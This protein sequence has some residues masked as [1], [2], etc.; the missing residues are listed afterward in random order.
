VSRELHT[1][2][3]LLRCPN[4]GDGKRVHEAVV[5]TLDHLRAWPAS[6]PW[7][8]FEPSVSASETYCRESA[9]AFL[10][11]SALVYLAFDDTGALVASTSLHGIDW[12]VPKFEVGFWCRA[13]RQRQ[14]LAK[15][16]V[17]E[18][19][20][21]AFEQL[22]AQRV[23]ALPDEENTSSRAVCESVG[24]QLEGVMRNERITPEGV[25]RNTCVYAAVRNKDIGP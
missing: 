2:R 8:M 9:A 4:A 18:L 22:G 10:R 1:P 7:A 11:R 20:R 23:L 17:A 16:A 24:M 3:L 13:S 15:E 12:A 19:V 14:G 25:L 5:E 21:H 6:L